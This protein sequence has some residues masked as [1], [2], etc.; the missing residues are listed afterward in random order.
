MCE[1]QHATGGASLR[2][3]SGGGLTR[4]SAARFPFCPE[5]RQNQHGHGD[6]KQAERRNGNAVGVAGQNAQAAAVHEFDVNPI[7]QQ[8]RLTELN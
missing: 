3:G 2:C 4:E 1:P 7:D 6:E 5:A 8:R